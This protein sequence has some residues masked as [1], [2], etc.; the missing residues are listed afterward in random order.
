MTTAPENGRYDVAYSFAAKTNGLMQQLVDA[1]TKQDN[2]VVKAIG[3]PVDDAAGDVNE[4][5]FEFPMFEATMLVMEGE[6]ITHTGFLVDLFC[7]DKPGAEACALNKT[8][9]RRRRGGVVTTPRR[10]GPDG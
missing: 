7:W 8:G 4:R 1:T 3:E 6:T 10:S 9:S 5:N 2:V